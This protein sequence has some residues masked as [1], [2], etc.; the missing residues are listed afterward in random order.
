MVVVRR[1]GKCRHCVII[2]DRSIIA[3][4]SLRV[5]RF[6]SY[7]PWFFT[8]KPVAVLCTIALRYL[9]T[10]LWGFLLVHDH[11]M[12]Q[13]GRQLCGVWQEGQHRHRE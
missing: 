9:I 5:A 3:V 4:F 12:Q 7:S 13:V 1:I 8:K 6:E 10:A 2:T 11:K